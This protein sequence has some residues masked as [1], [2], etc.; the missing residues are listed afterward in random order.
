MGFERIIAKNGEQSLKYN[1]RQIYSF[2]RPKQDAKDFVNNLFDPQANEYVL[3]GLGLGYHL[4]YLLQLAPRNKQIFVLIVEEEEFQIFEQSEFY[5]EIMSCDNVQFIQDNF[6]EIILTEK[7]Q[8]IIPNVWLQIIN[9]EH[10]L[11]LSLLDIKIKQVSFERFKEKLNL[12]FEHNIKNDDFSL[13]LF[14]RSNDTAYLVA[15]GPS[16][17]QTISMLKNNVEGVDIY[18]VGSAL[19][20]LLLDGIQP[21]GVVISDSQD[22]IINQVDVENKLFTLFYLATANFKAVESYQGNRCILLQH[23]YAKSE[24]LAQL[25]N[26]D[27]LDTGGSVSTLAFSLIEMLGYKNLVLFGQDFGFVGSSTH[28][29]NSTSGRKVNKNDKKMQLLSNGDTF[30][31]TTPNLYSYWKWFDWKTRRT[32][33]KVYTTSYLGAKIDQ[34]LY[35]DESELK[36]ILKQ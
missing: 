22:E 5:N 1:G 34:V 28:A 13:E 31:Y 9:K 19:K 29:E 18:C 14:K 6:E 26:Y 17:Q 35:L 32:T 33:V 15:S 30:I 20:L 16:L 25:I 24:Q 8:L 36:R 27:L 23:N 10:P 21:K 7:T 3:I 11:Y 4:Y 2:Y 12:N